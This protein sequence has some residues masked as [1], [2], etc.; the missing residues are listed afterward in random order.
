V[1]KRTKILV[2]SY[3]KNDYVPDIMSQAAS[4]KDQTE[5]VIT[6]IALLSQTQ[7]LTEANLKNSLKCKI[8]YFSKVNLEKM[9]ENGILTQSNID[10]VVT[11]EDITLFTKT[12][13]A[14]HKA[15]LLNETNKIHIL[16]HSFPIKFSKAIITLFDANLI[17]QPNI[18]LLLNADCPD[19]RARVYKYLNELNMFTIDNVMRVNAVIEINYLEEMLATLER[20]TLLT[21]ENCNKFLSPQY[22]ALLSEQSYSRK[23]RWYRYGYPQGGLT[24]DQIDQLFHEIDFPPAPAIPVAP[25]A[26]LALPL[27][28]HQH[29][30]EQNPVLPP[31]QPL[32]PAH[33]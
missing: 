17:S 15:S 12:L 19:S 8:D 18:N 24:Q 2:E 10:F 30:N 26:P 9:Y 31:L 5:F 21:I 22:G 14:L 29:Q 23:W 28:N 3:M 16:T 1:D 4:S 27:F 6:L 20:H 11:Y 13:L 25:V 7:L 33:D 32:G